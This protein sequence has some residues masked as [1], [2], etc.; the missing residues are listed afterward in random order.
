MKREVANDLLK[1]ASKDTKE[2]NQYSSD[3]RVKDS[4]E[5]INK[6]IK[7]AQRSYRQRAYDSVIA[8]SEKILLDIKK[9]K[10]SVIDQ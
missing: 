6:R 8:D 9:I 3:P 7:S 1:R 2:L 10:K 4:I 5:D